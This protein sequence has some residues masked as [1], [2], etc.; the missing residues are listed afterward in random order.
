MGAMTSLRSARRRM[1]AAL[2]LA[3]PALLCVAPPLAAQTPPP[4]SDPDQP[5][6]IDSIENI[7][8]LVTGPVAT[9]VGVIAVVF[10]GLLL[11]FGEAGANKR[12]AMMI[13]GVGL[14]LSAVNLVEY[15]TS[16]SS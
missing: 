13:I 11:A 7:Q 8:N 4:S 2:L 12:V 15:L 6:I 10:G 1:A 14:A 3:L 9:A 16:S 5:A